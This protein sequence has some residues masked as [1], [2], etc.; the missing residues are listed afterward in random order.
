MIRAARERT[1]QQQQQL[2][3]MQRLQF[4]GVANE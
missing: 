1:R 2:L 4:G 3:I